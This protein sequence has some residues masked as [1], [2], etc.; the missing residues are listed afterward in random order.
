MLHRK[1]QHQSDRIATNFKLVMVKR[2]RALRN[3][4]RACLCHLPQRE[5]LYMLLEASEPQPKGRNGC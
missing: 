4:S 2:L 3:L 1:W 5:L